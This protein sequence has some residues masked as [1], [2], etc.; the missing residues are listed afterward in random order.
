[1]DNINR[2][3]IENARI[4]FRNFKGREEKFNREGN[5]NFCVIIDDPV[6]AQNLANDGW[7]IKE[8]RPRDEGDE[9]RHYI[10]VT[11]S[12]KQRPPKVVM[13]TKNRKTQLDEETIEILDYADIKNVDLTI[14]PYTWE[15]SGKTGVK[16]YLKTMYVTIEEDAIEEKYAAEEFPDE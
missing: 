7:N 11:V 10:Q 4:I 3:T 13:I 9:P 15:V 16:A 8:L 2:L 6:T 1:M 12:Y 5:R 14:N